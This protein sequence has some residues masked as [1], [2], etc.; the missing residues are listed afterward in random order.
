M[1]LKQLST[2]LGCLYRLRPSPLRLSPD[3]A[4]VPSPSEQW[5]LEAVLDRPARVRLGNT[6]THNTI[7]MGA[8]NIREYRTP[9]FLL[10]RCQLTIAEDT[11]SIEPIVTQGGGVAVL[12]SATDAVQVRGNALR[13][14]EYCARREQTR[15]FDYAEADE[16][17]AALDLA[18]ESY[19]EA[20][21]DLANL[22]LVVVHP[23]L[24]HAS[25]VART[26]IRAHVYIA[27]AQQLFPDEHIDET[28]KDLF[29]FLKMVPKDQ[30]R[31]RVTDVLRD[32]AIPLPR[33]DLILRGLVDMGYLE[34]NGPGSDEWG[35]Y[36]DIEL[37]TQGRR[38]LRGDEPFPYC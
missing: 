17:I 37:T 18:P 32:V 33:L 13:L 20:A 25:G 38:T 2:Q 11:V 5:R 9:D 3:G 12:G 30:Y 27:V 19:R 22:G 26:I 4:L 29:T 28:L 35:S 34:G 16:A 31:I 24:G 10:L 14:L 36:L 8:D 7:E 23:N 6:H 15:L 1:N 21:E